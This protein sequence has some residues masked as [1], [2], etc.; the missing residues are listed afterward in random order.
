MSLLKF[1]LLSF[2]LYSCG[3]RSDQPQDMKG[4]KVKNQKPW[5]KEKDSTRF[6]VTV[7]KK[8]LSSPQ[9]KNQGPGKVDTTIQ[10][11]LGEPNPIEKI[12]GPQ[13]KNKKI[14]IN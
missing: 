3:K 13:A 2:I 11:K 7:E 4:P 12:T 6:N 1:F 10:V 8:K 9:I 14:V 5:E